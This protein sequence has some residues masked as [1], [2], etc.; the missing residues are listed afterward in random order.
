[1]LVEDLSID[2][3]RLYQEIAII[4]EKRDITEELRIHTS[5]DYLRIRLQIISEEVRTLEIIDPIRGK[6]IIAYSILTF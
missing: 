6:N 3:S 1:M 2:E 4:A 5:I